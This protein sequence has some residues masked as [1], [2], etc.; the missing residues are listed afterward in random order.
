[1]QQQQ[2][3]NKVFS[4]N[5]VFFVLITA[6]LVTTFFWVVSM[7]RGSRYQLESIQTMMADYGYY[8]SGY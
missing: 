7:N 5:T 2:R 8:Y 4:F 1:M 3:G 6:Q